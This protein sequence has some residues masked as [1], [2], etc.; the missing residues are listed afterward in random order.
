MSKSQVSDQAG[1]NKGTDDKGVEGGNVIVM[2]N[3]PH[4]MGKAIKLAGNK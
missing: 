2:N 4:V 1:R 3:Y